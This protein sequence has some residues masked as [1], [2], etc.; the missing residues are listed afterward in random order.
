MTEQRILAQP[1]CKPRSLPLQV[2]MVLTERIRSGQLKRGDQL[3]TESQLMAEQGVSRTV[4]REAM[5]RLQASGQ[6]ETRHGIG[7]SGGQP[8]TPGLKADS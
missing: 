2:E 1:K 5:S 7:T 6:V 8:G 4:V 3:P